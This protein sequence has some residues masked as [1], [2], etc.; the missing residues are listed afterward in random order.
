MN[1]DRTSLQGHSRFSSPYD[2]STRS[3]LYPEAETAQ[4]GQRGQPGCT[5]TERAHTR[6]ATETQHNSQPETPKGRWPLLLPRSRHRRRR[7][8]CRCCCCCCFCCAAAVLLLCCCC[9][10]AASRPRCIADQNPSQQTVSRFVFCETHAEA[11]NG[12]AA[13]VAVVATAAAAAAEQRQ[14]QVQQQGRPKHTYKYTTR[15]QAG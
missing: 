1:L 3:E 4:P 9:A 6:S 8:R 13:A 15:H 5:D 14:Q 10:A 11:S 12:T 2:W 7:R